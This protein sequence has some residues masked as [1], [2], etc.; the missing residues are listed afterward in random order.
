MGR[1]V[2]SAKFKIQ[3]AKLQFKIQS[4][5]LQFK[6]QSCSSKFKIQSARARPAGEK[7]QIYDLNLRTFKI[8]ILV[9]IL[10]GIF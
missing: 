8:P 5:K 7:L 9:P 4:V 6:V 10:M 2:R 1:R 3:S